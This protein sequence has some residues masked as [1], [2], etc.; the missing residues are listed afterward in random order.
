M[1]KRL[2]LILLSCVLYGGGHGTKTG[3]TGT[4]C[5]NCDSSHPGRPSPDS[6]KCRR[7]ATWAR[8]SRSNPSGG[9]AGIVRNVSLRASRATRD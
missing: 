4:R 2:S 6:S 5:G 8:I 7:G 9:N 1:R 3:T